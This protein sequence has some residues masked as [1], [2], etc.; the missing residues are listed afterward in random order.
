MFIIS[1]FI[2]GT[3]ILIFLFIFYKISPKFFLKKLNYG[4]VNLLLVC[5]KKKKKLPVMI[6]HK[7][8]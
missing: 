1:D 2:V 7:N 4:H 8:Q 6:P 5:E 3:K